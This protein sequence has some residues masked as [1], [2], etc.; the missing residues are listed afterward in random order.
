MQ[1][2]PANRALDQFFLDARC[3]LLDV[4][5]TLDRIGRGENAE[6]LAA[7]PRLQRIRAAV[8]VLLADEPGKA[9]RI[10]QLF[11]LDYDPDWS[12]PKPRG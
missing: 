10:Q 12:R 11:S 7:D 5:A 4:A 1:P 6:S 8:A 2:L 9:E 3:R